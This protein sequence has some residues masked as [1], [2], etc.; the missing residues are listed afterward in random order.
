[1]NRIETNEKY[2]LLIK[3]FD[4]SAFSNELK[5]VRDELEEQCSTRGRF[6]C[7]LYS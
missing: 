3:A 2:D 5:G 4:D 1:M 6:Y 7:T